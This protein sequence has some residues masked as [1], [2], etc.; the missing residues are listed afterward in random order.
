M[1]DSD[2]LRLLTDQRG[3]TVAEITAYFRVTETAIRV[4]LRRLTLSQSVARRRGDATRKRGRPKY[5][6]Y[7]TG[8]AAAA[9]AAAADEGTA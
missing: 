6:Y 1:C 9:L 2:I 5:L 3:R 8:R 4:R 7:I